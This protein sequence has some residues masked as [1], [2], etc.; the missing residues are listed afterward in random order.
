MEYWDNGSGY[1]QKG[2]PCKGQGHTPNIMNTDKQ[3]KHMNIYKK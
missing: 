2:N 3:Q 1:H